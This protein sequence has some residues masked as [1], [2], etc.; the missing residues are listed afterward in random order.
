MEL[1]LHS[2][3]EFHKLE[4]LKSSR[5]L[6]ILQTMINLYIFF[7]TVYLAIFASNSVLTQLPHMGIW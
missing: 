7:Q 5:F 4:F 1:K 2:K 6:I 3:L